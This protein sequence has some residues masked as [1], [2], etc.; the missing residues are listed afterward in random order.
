MAS[1]YILGLFS[2]LSVSSVV[3]VLF[4]PKWIH[5]PIPSLA[6]TMPIVKIKKI[7]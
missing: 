4:Q 5:Y 7:K 6:K 1:N 3:K 2:V